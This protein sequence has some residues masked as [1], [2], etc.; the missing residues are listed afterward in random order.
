ML[1]FAC[2]QFATPQEMLADSCA[3]DLSSLADSDLDE[4]LEEASDLVSIIT[5]G[6]VTGRCVQTLRPY[7]AHY[8]NSTGTCMCGS[9]A[10]PLFGVDPE[11]LHVY[12]DGVELGADEYMVVKG[13]AGSSLLKTTGSWPTSQSLTLADSELNT[14]AVILEWG[15]HIGFIERQATLELACELAKESLG[16]ENR[17]PVGARSATIGGV[18]IGLRERGEALREG[19]DNLP[20]VARLIGKYAGWGRAQSDVWSPEMGQG[21]TWVSVAPVSS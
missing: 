8:C 18:A 11:V 12:I 21:W 3:C 10:L 13:P 7:V 19:D 15:L 4:I 20:R 16:S 17:L 14:F 6:R 9:D 2:S 1:Q 5:G